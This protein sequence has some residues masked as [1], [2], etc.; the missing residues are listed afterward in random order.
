M[1]ERSSASSML[2]A[3]RQELGFTLREVEKITGGQISNAYLSQL[4]NG[5][6]KSPSL[7]LICA[8]AAAYAVS[9]ET[10]HDWLNFPAVEAPPLCPTCGRLLIGNRTHQ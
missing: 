8:L 7:R 2:K 5:R 10:I 9:V 3:R 6:I 1:V 4:E